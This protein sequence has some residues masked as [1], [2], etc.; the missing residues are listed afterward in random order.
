MTDDRP[1]WRLWCGLAATLALVVA[2]L[3]GASSG[4]QI[5]QST[6]HVV[7]LRRAN[8]EDMRWETV[9]TVEYGGS[10]WGGQT[11][12]RFWTR[13]GRPIV[14]LCGANDSLVVE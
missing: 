11:Q 6:P 10:T 3:F 5:A 12:W 2:I 14:I 8:G 9:G 1:T 7:T 13:E 4:Y